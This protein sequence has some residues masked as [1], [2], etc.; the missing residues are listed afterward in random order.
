MLLEAIPRDNSKPL[1]ILFR[2]W[3]VKYMN[4]T[5]CLTNRWIVPSKSKKR[6]KSHLDLLYN[7]PL[8]KAEYSL[9][10]CHT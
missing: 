9:Y 3:Y 6:R 10:M 7:D 8:C 5:K 2:A 4:Y 1:A